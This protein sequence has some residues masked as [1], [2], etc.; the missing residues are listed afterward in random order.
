M[1]QELVQGRVEQADADRQ[2]LHDLEQL[3]EILAL[4]RQQPRQRRRT[5]LGRVGKDHLAHHDQAVFLEEHVLGP[6]QTDPLRLEV[7]GGLRIGGR[8]GIGP[9]P[10]VAHG[11][12]PAKKLAE[13][14][15]QRRG[16]HFG[17]PRQRLARRAVDGDDVAFAEHPAI[18]RR[19]ASVS[20][21]SSR[22]SEAPTTQGRPSPRAITA[23]W[24]VMPPR[25]VST[26]AAEC[27]PRIS[28]GAVSRRTRMQ[29]SPRAAL[30]CAASDENTIRPVAAPGEAAMPLHEHVARR[31]RIDLMVQ[32]FR[33][34][35]RFDPQHR[36]VLRDDPVLG[37]RHRDPQAR[38]ATTA[39]P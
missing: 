20:R 8:V 6:A 13:G 17:R 36:L 1:R 28:S 34:R 11:I 25:S 33:Q 38:R 10:D 23:A 35:P 27:I 12:G 24:L 32:Q 26:A 37:Q 3:D 5:V 18:R 21:P 14:I 19:P 16:Q 31:A 22:R 39:A 4:H 9:H 7:A 29:G 2:A 30:A 15:V